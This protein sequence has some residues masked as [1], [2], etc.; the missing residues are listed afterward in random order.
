MMDSRMHFLR[1]R[2]C[3]VA[4]WMVLAVCSAMAVVPP[5]GPES[6][7]API[8]LQGTGPYHRLT[9]PAAIYGHAAYTDLRDLRITNGAG[10]A[11][12]F[13]WL[14]TPPSEQHTE[15]HDVPLFAWPRAAGGA[16]SSDALLAFKVRPDG[17]LAVVKPSA[18]PD[19]RASDWLMDLSQLRGRLLQARLVVEPG[20]QG[21]FPFTLE[22]SDD[23]RQWFRVGGDEQLVVLQQGQQHIERLSVDLG[24]MQARFLR[25]HWTDPQH[26]AKLTGVGIDTVRSTEPVAALEWS[27]PL[28]TERCA[29]DYCDYVLPSG[30]P[31]HSVRLQLA[32]PNTLA[33]IHVSGVLDLSKAGTP[34]PVVVHNPLYALRRLHRQPVRPLTPQEIPLLDTVVYRLTQPG[35]E[36]RSPEWPLNGAVYPRLRVRTDGPFSM[37]GSAAPT[38]EVSTALRTLVFL[39]Q[40]QP[41]YSVTWNAAQPER[42]PAGA[43]AKAAAGGAL[44]LSSLIP[45]YQPDQPLAAGLATVSLAGA[46]SVQ[47][48]AVPGVLGHGVAE[49]VALAAN[50]SRKPWLWAALLVGLL[51]LAGMA[52]SLF[53]SL[54]NSPPPSDDSP[55]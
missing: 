25:L 13:A 47:A 9:L 22:A 21:L 36:A 2:R 39:A 29:A 10:Q 43:H 31:A 6:R 53:R 15:S 35:G 50:D 11:V 19:Q 5:A 38:L 54:Q 26:G 42:T 49:Q 48:S 23:L 55:T 4:A 51:L 27:G 32:E 37:L 20:T 44:A 1:A 52:W 8:T 28:Q 34:V 12:P 40:G 45:G 18:A 16:E 3:A 33:S 30:V 24:G 7:S 14:H 41:P 46:S 17:S